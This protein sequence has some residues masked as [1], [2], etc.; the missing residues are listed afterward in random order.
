MR[1]SLRSIGAVVAVAL[2]SACSSDPVRVAS[3][4]VSPSTATRAVG[5]SVQLAATTADAKGASLSGRAV[6]WSSS[7]TSFATVS[8][9]GL[10][11]GVAPGAVIVTA[12]SEAQTGS[13]AITVIPPPVASVTVTPATVSISEIQSTQLTAVTKIA[14]GAAVTGRTVTWSSS[15]PTVATVSATGLVAGVAPGTATITA[16]SEGKIGTSALTVTITPCNTSLATLITTGQTLSGTINAADCLF[17]SDSTYADI[18]RLSLATQTT[19]AITMKSTVIDSYLV[20]FGLNATGTALVDIGE[21][22]DSGAT[23]GGGAK[24]AWLGGVE[25]AGTYFIAANTYGPKD[26]GAYTL[27]FVSPIA[28]LG[29]N[30]LSIERVAPADVPPAVRMALRGMRHR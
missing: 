20:L 11:T 28:I 22:D 9:D 6:T 14:N 2:V 21:D 15:A 26:F 10:V 3:V 12:T 13:A 30:V 24:D 1:L 29:G 18:Y 8:A 5:E 16:T 19:L 23:H 25:P 4:T 27:N 17:T 7:N